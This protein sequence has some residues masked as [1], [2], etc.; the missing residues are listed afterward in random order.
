MV[1][2]RRL[3]LGVHRWI[4]LTIGLILA[5]LGITGAAMVLRTPILKWEVGA[6]PLTLHEAPA[7]GAAYTSPQAWQEA[8]LGA[9]P[10]L[11]RA[12]GTAAPRGGF[13]M[14]DNA[15]VFGPLQGRP[16]MGIAMVDPYTAAPRGFFVFDDLWLAKVVAFHRSLMLPPRPGALTLAACGMVLLASL[17]TG[18]WL[19]WPRGTFPGRWRR[20]FAISLRSRG[21]QLWLALHNLAA[22]YLFV[23]LLLLAVSGVILAQPTWF[24]WLGLSRGPHSALSALHAQLMLGTVGE[25]AT[26]LAGVALPVLYVTG[27]SMWWRKRSA[28]RLT[29]R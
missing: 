11:Q 27:L 23:P 24:A 26:F 20:A 12:I 14:S 16:G 2:G 29:N 6:G 19:W 22:V 9:Y 8:A 25:V 5:L 15:M 13:L 21:V 10:Q 17:L 7:P 4:A 18:L 3:W 28:R 1:A